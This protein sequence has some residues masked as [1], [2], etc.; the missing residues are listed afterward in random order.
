ML[1][2]EKMGWT[3]RDNKTEVQRGWDRGSISGAGP[4]EAIADATKAVVGITELLYRSS[5][6]HL[7][8]FHQNWGF[9]HHLSSVSMGN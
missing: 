8:R 7:S 1:E 5:L 4:S 2:P 9:E 3:Y 6:Q